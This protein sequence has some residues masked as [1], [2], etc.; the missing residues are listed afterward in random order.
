M[1]RE[2]LLVGV[3]VTVLVVWLSGWLKFCAPLSDYHRLN[4]VEARLDVLEGK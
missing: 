1:G 3:A 4:A 2:S